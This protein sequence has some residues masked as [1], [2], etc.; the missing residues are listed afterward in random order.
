MPSLF[1]LRWRVVRN[2]ELS[3]FHLF[4]RKVAA[5]PLHLGGAYLCF[6]RWV[7]DLLTR[8]LKD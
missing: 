6:M 8:F 1:L 3:Q 7:V 2:H 5:A 4:G